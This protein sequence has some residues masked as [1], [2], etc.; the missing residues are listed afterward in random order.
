MPAMGK[1]SPFVILII[2]LAGIRNLNP[3]AGR[4]QPID[5]M[6]EKKGRNGASGAHDGREASFLTLVMNR[7][8]CNIS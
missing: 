1:S 8:K 3:D 7:R 2:S 4:G 6:A 5:R